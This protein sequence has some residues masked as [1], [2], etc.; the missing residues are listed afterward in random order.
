MAYYTSMFEDARGNYDPIR[1]SRRRAYNLTRY[2]N[3]TQHALTPLDPSSPSHPFEAYGEPLP[4][5]PLEWPPMDDERRAYEAA[6]RAW[7]ERQSGKLYDMPGA[8]MRPEFRDWNGRRAAAA[9]PSRTG[10]NRLASP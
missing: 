6:A 3:A 9:R 10:P 2:Y 5:P 7:T 4:L 1:A 8:E